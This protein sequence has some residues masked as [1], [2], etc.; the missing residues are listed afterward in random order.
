[1]VDKKK[2]GD[3]PTSNK[4]GG[5]KKKEGGK[6]RFYDLI[7][8][9]ICP[10]QG[11]KYAWQSWAGAKVFSVVLWLASGLESMNSRGWNMAGGCYSPLLYNEGIRCYIDIVY[12]P[13]TQCV[14]VGGANAP[15]MIIQPSGSLWFRITQKRPKSPNQNFSFF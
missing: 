6:L 1:M 12:R 10:Y 7:F 2:R 3:K 11:N 8:F 15:H 5:T 9:L 14:M 4:D 13:L